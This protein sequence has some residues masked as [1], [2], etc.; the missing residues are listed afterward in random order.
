MSGLQVGGRVNRA[1]KIGG[2]G[3]GKRAQL[4]GTI[5]GEEAPLCLSFMSPRYGEPQ[6]GWGD[7]AT[8][9]VV[10]LFGDPRECRVT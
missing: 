10:P 1:P 6:E 7:V 8:F 3:F 5:H 2:G 9:D 4:T